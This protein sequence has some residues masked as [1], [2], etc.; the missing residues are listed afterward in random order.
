MTFISPMWIQSESTLERWVHWLR[1][2]SW[3]PFAWGHS[4]VCSQGEAES[5]RVT[6]KMGYRIC[7]A[8]CKMKILCPCWKIGISRQWVRSIK[9]GLGPC[10][11][12]QVT[13]PGSCPYSL[14]HDVREQNLEVWQ[15][16]ESLQ[17]NP[18]RK[19]TW[20]VWAPQIWMQNPLR[21]LA[22]DLTTWWPDKKRQ[23]N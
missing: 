7:G 5:H 12:L 20:E 17:P 21:S 8:R 9:P 18:R 11:T 22:D 13:R 10:G 15:Q 3:C 23:K 16:P 6:G 14:A 2:V 19:G 1:F 4:L